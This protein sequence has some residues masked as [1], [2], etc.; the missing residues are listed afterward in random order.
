MFKS[1]LSKFAFYYWVKCFSTKS[2]PALHS[3]CPRAQIRFPVLESNGCAARQKVSHSNR[4]SFLK[5]TFSGTSSKWHTETMLESTGRNW[6]RRGRH[7][8]RALAAA[9]KWRW[10]RGDREGRSRRLEENDFE[11]MTQFYINLKLARHRARNIEKQCWN[12]YLILPSRYFILPIP[13]V[14][15]SHRLQTV[16]SMIFIVNCRKLWKKWS[17]R[18]SLRTRCWPMGTTSK[19]TTSLWSKR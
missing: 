8:R 11:E 19:S 6:L 9:G 16:N 12:R 7:W 3:L 13:R 17:K 15:T 4:I 14:L 10:R 1:V 2:I 18:R 5:P